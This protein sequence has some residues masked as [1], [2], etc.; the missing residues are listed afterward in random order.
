MLLH[1]VPKNMDLPLKGK[2]V[3]IV[4][5]NTVTKGVMKDHLI[6]LGATQINTAH[7]SI[8]ARESLK[9]TTP[10]LIVCEY[11]LKDHHNGQQLLEEL[12]TQGSLDVQTSFIL[13]SGE[14]R[15]NNIVSVAEMEP[16]DYL[17]KPFTP[18]E[19]TER[20]TRLMEKK[21]ILSPVL[22]AFKDK[23]YGDVVNMINPLVEQHPN[24]QRD[25]WKLKLKAYTHLSQWDNAIGD[26]AQWQRSNPEPWVHLSLAEMF[27]KK[28]KW[29]GAFD[30]VSKL[31]IEHPHYLAA[32]D[33]LADVLWE[34]NRPDAAMEVLEKIGAVG[35][36]SCSRLRK[37]ADLSMRLE[38]VDKAK[39]YLQKLIGRTENSSMTRVDDYVNLVGIYH[40]QG[41]TEALTQ[42][43]SKMKQTVAEDELEIGMIMIELKQQINNKRMD[44]ANS[45]L[46]KGFN[47]VENSD[48]PMAKSICAHLIETCFE[49]DQVQ[50]GLSHAQKLAQRSPGKAILDR[51]KEIIEHHNSTKA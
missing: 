34:L 6:E 28:G 46:L 26:L 17:I 14:R 45:L 24:L 50:L 2:S 15:F 31:V 39:I 11:H 41:Q 43:E 18:F 25:L 36:N 40:M 27:G 22:K 44:K 21:A 7:S 12:K 51:L 19:I 47:R 48:K 29:D 3:L 13:V 23:R 49:L 20:V 4:D 1:K 16:D 37:I 32:K 30:V 35:M 8:E 42:L 9:K 33:L 10:D 5:Q 38:Q